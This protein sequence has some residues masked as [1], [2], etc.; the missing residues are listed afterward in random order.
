MLA[1]RKVELRAIVDATLTMMSGLQ[2]Q[3]AAGKISHEEALARLR[4][5]IYATRFDGGVGYVFAY[6]M[7]GLSVANGANPQIEGVRFE[8]TDQFDRS[9]PPANISEQLQRSIAPR[10]IALR[11]QQEVDYLSPFPRPGQ[12]TPLPKL[13]IAKQFEPWHIAVFTGLWTDDIDA[14]FRQALLAL[15]AIGLAIIVVTNGI[16]YLISRSITTSLGRLRNRMTMLAA[17][18]DTVEIVEA[19]RGDEIGDMAKAVQVFKDGMIDAKRLRTEQEHAKALAEEEKRKALNELADAF[20][21]SVKVEVGLLLS[22]SKEMHGA[23]QDL[24]RTA[25]DTNKQSAIVAAA[26]EE[27]AVNVQTVASATEELSASITE[28]GRQVEHSS[29]ISHEAVEQASRTNVTVDGLAQAAQRIGEVIKMIQD[30]AAQTNLLALNA[31]IEAAR[32]GEA[33][34][35]F[36][37]VASEV[38]ALA[39]QTSRATEEIAAQIASIQGATSEVVTAIGGIEETIGR[40]NETASAIAAA[41]NEQ[42]AATQ[43]IAS[44]VQQVSEG[45]TEISSNIT[46]VTVAAGETGQASSRMLTGSAELATRAENLRAQVDQFLEAVRVA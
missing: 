19:T 40:I 10:L 22:S 18:D 4:Q 21:H 45:T 43:E 2:K 14:S 9:R 1:D 25:E 38:K 7:D 16:V 20:E 44:N 32:A 30:I 31:T 26:A 29:G 41:V 35:G 37:V 15:G 28:I 3:E 39:A 8:V 34:K 6:T 11:S 42:S 46:S 23:A 36:A 13:F 33:G 12:K 17:G 24:S 27:A 5:Y